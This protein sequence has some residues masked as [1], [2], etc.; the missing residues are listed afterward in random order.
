MV[1]HGTIFPNLETDEEPLHLR[2]ID[3]YH[4]LSTRLGGDLG[5]EVGP[6]DL[7]SAPVLHGTRA[8]VPQVGVPQADVLKSSACRVTVANDHIR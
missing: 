6:P 2:S 8:D 7:L 1:P 3:A 4:L 5:Q